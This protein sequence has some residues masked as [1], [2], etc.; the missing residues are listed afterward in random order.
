M[1]SEAN[2]LEENFHSFL[3]SSRQVLLTIESLQHQLIEAEHSEVFD[4]IERDVN[5]L[6]SDVEICRLQGT[7]LCS[8]SEQYSKTVETELRN[9]L[10]NFEELNRR[11]NIAQVR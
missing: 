2:K 6:L 3:E 7:E 11:L 9:V 8:K 5:L 4:S 1:H 10:V